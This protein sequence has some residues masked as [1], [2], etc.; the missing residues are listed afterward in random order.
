[1]FQPIV[2][3]GGLGGWVFLNNTKDVQAE[4]F[5][6]SPQL[7]RDTDYFQ[8]RIGN[9]ISA[10]DLVSDR[11]LLRVALGA[12]GLQEDID[13]RFLIKKVLED[14]TSDGAALANRLSDERYKQFSEAFGFGNGPVARTQLTGFGAEIVAKYRARAFEIAVG[15]QDQN[16]RLAMNAERE[17]AEIGNEDAAEDTRWFRIMGT[18]PLRKVFESA[19]GLPSGFGQL[20]IDKQLEVFKERARSV[21]GVTSLD[22]MTESTVREKVIQTYLLREQVNGLNQHS[23]NSIALTLLQGARSP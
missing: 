10:E 13:N 23:S 12:F 5:N 15:S 16:L 19:F 18:P 8:E 21:F 3:V 20:D 4:T 2:P 14:G 11:R 22:E 6:N 9:V 17:L 7:V 1:M